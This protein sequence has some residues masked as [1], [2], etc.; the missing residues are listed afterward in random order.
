M[1]AAQWLDTAMPTAGSVVTIGVFDGVHAGHRELI[2][3]TVALAQAQELTAVAVTFDPHPMHVVRGLEIPLLMTTDR[4]RA[5]LMSEGIAA[6]EIC[7]FDAGRAN[8]LPEEFIDDVLIGRCHAQAIVVGEGFRFGRRASGSAAT[9]RAAGLEVH[10]VPAVQ[11]GIDRV[12]STR[13]RGA[14]IEGD[15]HEAR[16]LLGRPHRLEGPV[17]HGNKRGR[18]IGYPTANLGVVPGLLVPADGVYAGW[19]VRGGVA[20]GAQG[21][22]RLPAAISIGTNPTFADVVERRVEAY[23]LDRTDLDLYDEYVGIDFVS[24]IRGM[25]KFDDIEQLMQAMANDVAAARE[26]LDADA[27]S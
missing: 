14:L 15:V 8:Q 27:T 2:H 4:R 21:S 1:T 10:E 5:V 13:I 11:S 3:R 20:A 6:V 23:V 12:S 16:S 22:E 17:V 19:L 26:A 25:A 9:L 18:T 24:R 7:A